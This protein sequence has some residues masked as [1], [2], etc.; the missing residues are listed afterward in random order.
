[1][2]TIECGEAAG[3]FAASSGCVQALERIALKTRLSEFAGIAGPSSGGKSTLHR[4]VA[5]YIEASTGRVAVQVM[6]PLWCE[7]PI[8][9]GRRFRWEAMHA[10]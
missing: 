7:E 10:W 4:L 5:G 1:M 2:I 3:S 8:H 9:A 6:D